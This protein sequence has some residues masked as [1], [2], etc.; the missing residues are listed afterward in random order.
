M[1]V[2]LGPGW[3]MSPFY[4]ILL[5]LCAYPLASMIAF[6][7]ANRQAPIADNWLRFIKWLSFIVVG[8]M[9]LLLLGVLLW[10]C[11]YMLVVPGWFQQTSPFLLGTCL[12]FI[13]A[14]HTLVSRP[15]S[16][17]HAQARPHDDS[18]SNVDSSQEP[19]GYM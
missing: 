8:G 14:V 9:T 17:D 1:L 5:F 11:S 18:P 15:R 16:R 3:L 10:C 6:K 12:A 13:V 7:W 19:R 4:P 2:A